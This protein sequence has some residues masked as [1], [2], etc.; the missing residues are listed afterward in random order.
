MATPATR[1]REVSALLRRIVC[2]ARNAHRQFALPRPAALNFEYQRPAQKGADQNQP[3]QKTQTRKGKLDR[4]RLYDV[5]GDKYFKAQQ[6]GAADPYLVLIILL[7]ICTPVD[8]EISRP[9]DTGDDDED[10]EN[11]DADANDMN[12]ATYICLESRDALDISAH[13]SKIHRLQAR[14]TQRHIQIKGPEC[15][16]M[17]QSRVSE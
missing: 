7:R 13:R 9:D 15:V 10:A 11:F 8:T 1:D 12:P 14:L 16:D 17:D 2:L 4:Y 3:S 6:Q 5:G